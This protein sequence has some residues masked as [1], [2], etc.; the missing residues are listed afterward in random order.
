MEFVR[1]A[2]ELPKNGTWL[3]MYNTALSLFDFKD[4]GKVELIFHNR[5]EHLPGEMIT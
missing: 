1:A 5:V 3:T 2:L 4:D